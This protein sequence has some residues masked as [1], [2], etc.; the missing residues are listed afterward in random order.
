M[1]VGT[2]TIAVLGTALVAADPVQWG[3]LAG[4]GVLLAGVV[5]MG[6]EMILV[7]LLR[8]REQR[9]ADALDMLQTRLDEARGLE[10]VLEQGM[11]SMV[12][13]LEAQAGLAVVR[14]RE[15]AEFEFVTAWGFGRDVLDVRPRDL[16]GEDVLTALVQ[17]RHPVYV[18]L[19]E[20]R[21][22]ES[23]LR[24]TGMRW[25]WV[26]PFRAGPMDGLILAASMSG[27]PAHQVGAVLGELAETVGRSAENALVISRER[28]RARLLTHLA[29][30]GNFAVSSFEEEHL[31]KAATA[32]VRSMFP[33]GAG[34]LTALDPGSGALK[35]AEVFGSD[36]ERTELGGLLGTTEC[37]GADGC[38]AISRGGAYEGVGNGGLW[39]CPYRRSGE[40]TEAFACAPITSSDGPLG[41]IHIAQPTGEEFESDEKEILAALGIQLGLAIANGQLLAVTKDQALRDSMT[42]LHNYRYLVEFL[43]NQTALI[44]RT[45]GQVS[46]LMIDIDHFREFNNH[47]GHAAGDHVLRAVARRFR[48][49]IRKSDLAARYG[50]EEFT[51]VLPG[52]TM[53]GAEFLAET[54]RQ[55][56]EVEKLTFDGQDLGEINVS[57]GVATMPEH[58]NTVENLIKAADEALYAAKSAGRNQVMTATGPPKIPDNEADSRGQAG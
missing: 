27:T 2:A 16:L 53:E 15:S 35:V 7:R 43:N 46:V 25:L 56:I 9:H 18:D 5:L 12:D 44:Q 4:I 26:G 39:D 14:E 45:H 32:A 1:L 17:G 10:A 49:R 57:I 33:Q 29:D 19:E 37:D 3:R 28:E 54:I 42:G 38:R 58:A 20:E 11:L 34:Y 13:L 50:G 47:F 52:T 6:V 21:F 51:V 31:R 55:D 8:R 24:V 22:A 41:A 30:F 48:K 23:S 36:V 40:A